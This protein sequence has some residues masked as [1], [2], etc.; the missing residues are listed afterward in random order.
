MRGLVTGAALVW[1][2]CASPGWAADDAAALYATS[3]TELRAGRTAEAIA[4]LR[5]S[6]ELGHPPAQN[7]LGFALQHGTGMPRDPA[8]ALLWFRRAAEAGLPDAQRRLAHMLERGIGTPSDDE[9]GRL[10]YRRAAERGDAEAQ[11]RL[12]A[13]IEA[14]WH[15]AERNMAEAANLFLRAADQ[16]VGIAQYR[17]ALLFLRGDGVAQDDDVAVPLLMRAAEQR[18]PGAAWQ[19]GALTYDGRGTPADADAALHWF[20]LGAQQ[21]GD[22]ILDR[23]IAWYDLI[24]AARQNPGHSDMAADTE[25]LRHLRMA[26]DQGLAQAQNNLAA[27]LYRGW[28]AKQDIPAAKKLFQTAAASGNKAAQ[29]W[30]AWLDQ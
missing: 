23:A 22:L 30:L 21:D 7:A 24:M 29:A 18:V 14:G 13:L 4:A 11:V 17:L 25:A 20:Q 2:V 27:M 9:A 5:K 19:L 28:G 10:W 8:A 16:G 12:A 26:A 6:A 15:G 1:L 3:Q